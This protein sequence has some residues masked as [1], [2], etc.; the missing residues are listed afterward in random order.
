VSERCF[1][2]ISL[3]CRNS[4]KSIYSISMTIELDFRD[5]LPARLV[6]VARFGCGH[7]HPSPGEKQ[8]GVSTMVLLD[9]IQRSHGQKSGILKSFRNNLNILC[10]PISNTHQLGRNVGGDRNQKRK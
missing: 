5:F 3:T 9:T 2:T 7:A 6:Q 10:H 8:R 1:L 4:Q